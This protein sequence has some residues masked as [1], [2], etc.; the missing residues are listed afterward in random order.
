MTAERKRC[1]SQSGRGSM[2]ETLVRRLW[3]GLWKAKANNE[4]TA[5]VIDAYRALFGKENRGGAF[6]GACR[7]CG[8][9]MVMR[10]SFE[11]ARQDAN[12]PEQYVMKTVRERHKFMETEKAH[13][14]RE[15]QRETR[16]QDE[17][18]ERAQHRSDKPNSAELLADMRALSRKL[19]SERPP[20]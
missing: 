11:A 9:E 16:E 19:S 12:A 20:R 5:A 17:A 4:K 6:A 3:N 13:A 10:A 18:H 7:D 15:R 1:C 2:A 14:R 8:H